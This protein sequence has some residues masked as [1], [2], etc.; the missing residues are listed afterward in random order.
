[1]QGS[2]LSDPTF[3]QVDNV[4]WVNLRSRDSKASP[5]LAKLDRGTIVRVLHTGCGED[6]GWVRVWLP[7][8]GG[9]DDMQ[10]GLTGY[11]WHSYLVP[12]N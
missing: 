9:P 11:I 5:S 4:S 6:G 8:E 2:A 3:M 10:P 7:H 12:A 1:M